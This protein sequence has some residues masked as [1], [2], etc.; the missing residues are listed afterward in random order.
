MLV[1]PSRAASVKD[2]RFVATSSMIVLVV[3]RYAE[4][5]GSS[6]AS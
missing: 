2:G 5:R 4:T 3:T 6:K 1:G